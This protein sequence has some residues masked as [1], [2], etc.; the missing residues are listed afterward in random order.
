LAVFT[1]RESRDFR[2]GFASGGLAA[3][4]F[5]GDSPARWWRVALAAFF[6]FDVGINFS[7][8]TKT[9]YPGI[10]S[11]FAVVNLRQ[12]GAGRNGNFPA[13]LKKRVQ[14]PNG[15]LNVDMRRFMDWL[16]FG[17]IS[18]ETGLPTGGFGCS[19]PAAL[20][21]SS[22][23]SSQTGGSAAT[24][25]VVDDEMMLLE[26]AATILQPLGFDVRTF[27]DP[28]Q[29]LA[30]YPAA[31][32]AVVVTDYA[33]PGMNGLDLVRECRLINPG[34][35]TILLSGTVDE[36]V[37]AEAQAKPDCFLAKPYRISDFVES[38]QKLV[39]A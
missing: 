11:P 6:W 26:L 16:W 10:N 8:I 23:K 18:A 24:I 34:Q 28:K 12:E 19:I 7:F 14:L 22:I 13:C 2:A 29:A 31:R 33:M 38:I 27:H 32:P 36:H 1:T 20:G 21:M 35:K 39:N 15:P 37:F 9:V 3:A 30:E 25:F 5:S 4:V 17:I